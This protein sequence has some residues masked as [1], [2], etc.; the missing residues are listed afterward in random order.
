MAPLSHDDAL[1]MIRRIKGVS[2]SSRRA[3]PQAWRHRRAGE[4]LVGLGQ[5]AVANAGRFRA[6][7]LN[8]IIVRAE[9]EGVVAV[10]IAIEP[11]PDAAPNAVAHVAS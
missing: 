9:G 3:R 4:M 8:P 2:D 7:D 11:N 1:H 6:L 5:F 10:D